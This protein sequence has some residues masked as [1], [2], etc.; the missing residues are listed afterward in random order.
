[1]LP[2]SWLTDM[3]PDALEAVIAHELAHIRRWDVWANLL[4]RLVETLLFYHPAVWWLSR[5]LS[6][7]REMCA[8]ELAV[9]A[10]KQRVVYAEALELIGGKR[11]NET[12]G[13]LAAAMGGKEM[14]L[15]HRVRNVLGFAPS[16]ETT[17]WWPV[18]LL[19]LLVPAGLV[20][21][22]G[23]AETKGQQE[24]FQVERN[25]AESSWRHDPDVLDEQMRQAWQKGDYERA[26]LLNKMR[27]K[28]STYR[29]RETHQAYRDA[30]GA[31]V[32][33][34]RLTV[35][36]REG[37]RLRVENWEHGKLHGQW[38]D[39]HPDGHKLADGAFEHGNKTGRWLQYDRGGAVE[40]EEEYSNDRPVKS[41]WYG[42]SPPDPF[43]ERAAGRC[44][45]R[46]VMFHDGVI[47]SDALYWPNGNKR[48]ECLYRNGLQD[49]LT[50]AWRQT[51]VKQSEVAYSGGE[52]HGP[53]VAWHENGAKQFEGR[54]EKGCEV[55][56]WTWWSEDGV[57][58]QE[59]EFRDGLLVDGSG[60]VSPILDQ[61][62]AKGKAAASDTESRL[63]CKMAEALD[64]ETVLD[65]MQTP[66]RDVTSYLSDSHEIPVVIDRR[67]LDTAG[68]KRDAPVTITVWGI[69]LRAGLQLALKP[70]GL[71]VVY[72]HGVLL[73]TTLEGRKTWRDRTGVTELK[74]EP[75]SAIADALAQQTVLG[76]VDTPVQEIVRYLNDSHGIKIRLDGAVPAAVATKGVSIDVKGITL[77]SALGL[78]LDP[79]DLRCDLRDDALVV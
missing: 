17:R 77:R 68:V 39:W 47:A 18:G 7:E 57:T 19:A 42:A 44:R 9:A 11:L 55:G 64:Q 10:T 8:D 71:A 20:L 21:S 69:S 63:I 6:L 23:W 4:Q 30:R 35:Y 56:R 24:I 43:S 41:V 25:V 52:R 61:A 75:G 76:F 54:S 27:G 14:M 31:L 73:I 2:L 22:I 70:L 50:T 66:L 74:P 28:D 65:F 40:V 16:R 3:P 53:V 5:R 78:L 48:L 58:Q 46:G 32:R 51:G 36:D 29:Y 79:L 1:L 49:G 12:A 72:R 26:E 62:T 45:E 38:T 15:L 13:Q 33:H 67:A 34:G 60:N 37:N 59:A